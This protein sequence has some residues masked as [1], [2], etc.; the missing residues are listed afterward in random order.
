MRSHGSREPL[1]VLRSSLLA[2]HVAARGRVDRDVDVESLRP[3]PLDRR[4]R[5]RDVAIDGDRIPDVVAA[6]RCI[7]RLSRSLRA[8]AIIARCHRLIAM[9][10]L[11]FS[12]VSHH[13]HQAIG[14]QL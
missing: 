9:R 1:R 10:H 6:K 4:N 5:H 13:R 8:R 7:A 11:R 14:S 2:G 3:Q 12:R